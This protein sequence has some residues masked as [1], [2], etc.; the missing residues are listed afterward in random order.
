MTHMQGFVGLIKHL[1][2]T[3]HQCVL[4]GMFTTDHLEKQFGKLR[5]G[6]GGTYFI[7]VQQIV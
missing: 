6:W 1:M 4:F 7:S 3:S 5:Q 2:K